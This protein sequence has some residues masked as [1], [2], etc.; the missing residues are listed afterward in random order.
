MQGPPVMAKDLDIKVE[1]FRHRSLAAG[2]YT[3][4]RRPGVRGGEARLGRKT[5]TLR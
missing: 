1:V 5:Y 4:P 3:P 2:P